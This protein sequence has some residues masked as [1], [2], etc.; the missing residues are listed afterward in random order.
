MGMSMKEY[1]R[2]L[3]DTPTAGQSPYRIFEGVM[4]PDGRDENGDIIYVYD[5]SRTF[6]EQGG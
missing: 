1:I 3:W 2:Y 6:V 5:Q 4:K